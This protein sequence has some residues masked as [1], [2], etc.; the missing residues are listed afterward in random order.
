MHESP[1]PLIDGPAW[2]EFMVGS[3]D[4]IDVVVSD[5]YLRNSDGR[6]PTGR[7]SL[8]LQLGGGAVVKSEE[9]ESMASTP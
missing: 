8:V 3:S 1:Y 6:L 7:C 4:G 2:E 9:F 5:F